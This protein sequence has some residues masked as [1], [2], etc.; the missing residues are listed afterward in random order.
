[1]GEFQSPLNER[2]KEIRNRFAVEYVKCRDP[3]KSAIKVGYND[4]AA[5][6]YAVRFMNEAYTLAA[7]DI[8]E[9]MVENSDESGMSPEQL[10]IKRLLFLEAEDRT[11]G[12][13]HSAR[14][15][16]LSKLASICGMESPIRLESNVNHSGSLSHSFDFSS[17][18]KHEL[19]L[20]RKL[21][22]GRVSNDMES[23]GA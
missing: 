21:L 20:V 9:N 1:M 3:V 17:L 13:S 12:A 16:A 4:M 19:E 8:A 15:S 18:K 11:Y 23:T 22:E 14:V 10:K 5:R 7:I 6:E 2:E